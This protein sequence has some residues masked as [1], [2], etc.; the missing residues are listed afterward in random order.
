M[1]I[2]TLRLRNQFVRRGLSIM[3][4]AR[5]I[6]F[7]SLHSSISWIITYVST[8][9]GPI[10]WRIH[11]NLVGQDFR[12]VYQWWWSLTKAGLLSMS[13]GIS[14]VRL[15]YSR[16]TRHKFILLASSLKLWDISLTYILDTQ[17][18]A[19]VRTSSFVLPKHNQV[20]RVNHLITCQNGTDGGI[21]LQY[22]R[23][24]RPYSTASWWC[25][26]SALW[27]TPKASRV[28]EIVHWQQLS[29]VPCTTWSSICFVES[30]P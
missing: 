27:L 3:F 1:P 25:G 15:K 29:S 4:S 21:P 8:A 10:L 19:A 14:P 16:L 23:N 6:N 11:C 12:G 5:L 7:P 26:H 9:S 24:P 28:S 20:V 18:N 2:G 30:L 17:T 13:R 22:M